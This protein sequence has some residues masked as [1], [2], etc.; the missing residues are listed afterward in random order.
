MRKER[1]REKSVPDLKCREISWSLCL[2]ARVCISNA[3]TR[4]SK[5]S[6]NEATLWPLKIKISKDFF[7]ARVAFLCG[8]CDPP[9]LWGTNAPNDNNNKHLFFFFQSYALSFSVV[10][11]SVKSRSVG[12]TSGGAI[13]R[14]RM[15]SRKER[16]RERVCIKKYTHVGFYTT[17]FSSSFWV[18]KV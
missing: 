3:Y 7:S 13:G 15:R 18:L 17:L 14:A 5:R 9:R 6:K 1:V 10:R 12:E 11:M 2:S 8:F 16:E 4:A